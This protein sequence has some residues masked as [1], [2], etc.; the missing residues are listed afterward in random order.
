MYDNGSTSDDETPGWNPANDPITSLQVHVNGPG[1]CEV[2]V[3]VQQLGQVVPVLCPIVIGNFNI[4]SVNIAPGL[5]NFQPPT[6][7][8]P[9]QIQIV[10]PNI[11]CT[12]VKY[13][14]VTK[15][16]SGQESTFLVD[17]SKDTVMLKGL[18][19]GQFS[20]TVAGACPD[21]SKTPTSQPVT[22]DILCN[23]G[24]SY[25][26]QSGLCRLSPPPTQSPPPPS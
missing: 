20:V 9:P 25:D 2:V 17:A 1:K 22:V 7:T 10:K 16:S 19:S 24:Q 14:V 23:V 5:Q 6:S 21:G 15:S 4:S 18:S 26:Q 13:T 8:D 11:V 12:G 3:A